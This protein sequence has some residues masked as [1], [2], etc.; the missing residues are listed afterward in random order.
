M[1]L[2]SAL[3]AGASAYF[4]TRCSST[5]L[6]R[7]RGGNNS[8]IDSP[9]SIFG[10]QRFQRSRIN[11]LMTPSQASN[12]LDQIRM[13]LAAGL[14]VPSSIQEVAGLSDTHLSIVWLAREFDRNPTSALNDFRQRELALANAAHLLE[15]SFITGS[16]L[17]AALETMSDQLRK[18]VAQDV[19]RRVRA[20]GVKAV[21]PLGLCF[22]PAF[23]LLTVVPIA[24]GL[25][26]SMS[27]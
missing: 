21:M 15:R 12:I 18:Q 23:V 25:F 5:V 16:P 14:S 7:L 27:W 10:F 26:R 3:L 13:C 22:L 11:Q 1:I 8:D 17:N 24:V 6:K 9:D 4:A 2:C 19:T 20:V